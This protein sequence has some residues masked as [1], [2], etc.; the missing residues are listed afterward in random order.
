MQ[1]VRCGY[2]GLYSKTF[3]YLLYNKLDVFLWHII[4]E[5]WNVYMLY[6]VYQLPYLYMCIET[7]LYELWSMQKGVK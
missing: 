2:C 4:S 5:I 7:A 6:Y 1:W 3:V